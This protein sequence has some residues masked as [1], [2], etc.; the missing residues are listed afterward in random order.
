MEGAKLDYLM[1]H[2]SSV[3]NQETALE[4]DFRKPFAELK[5]H[6]IGK[7]G[8]EVLTAASMKMAVFWAVAPC[9]LVQVYQRFRG[10]CFLHHRPNDGGSNDHWNVGK[11]L[12][13]G[14]TTQ[15]TA[16][17][18]G[19]VGSPSQPARKWVG[20]WMIYR[21]QT[22]GRGLLMVRNCLS[23]TWTASHGA[24]SVASQVEGKYSHFATE[25]WGAV[26][27]IFSSCSCD[28]HFE[29]QLVQ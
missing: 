26:V 12:L 3:Q 19:K 5:G 24:I 10:P 17:L 16:I 22:V 27:S 18:I 8:F 6:L 14:A 1:S 7:A 11:L 28:L 15:K 25:F 29:P 9:S 4:W 21:K 13:H 20:D 2:E 23:F